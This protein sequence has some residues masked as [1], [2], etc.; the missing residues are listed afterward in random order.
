MP[1]ES[2]LRTG[3]R[4]HPCSSVVALRNDTVNPMIPAIALFLALGFLSLIF[5]ILAWV[6]VWRITRLT[7]RRSQLRWLAAWSLQGLLLPFVLWTLLNV[8]LSFDLQ[9]LMPQV[10]AAKN[11]GNEWFPEFL[12]VVASGLF[13][14]CS[15]WAALTLGWRL[16]VAGAGLEKEAL[17]NF[18]G[19]CLTSL[20]AM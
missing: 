3:I 5:V 2:R 9:P 15:Y 18:K 13:I 19:L 20:F 1:G 11:S 14:I 16:A 12:A 6:S 10:Q 7:K 8:G 4:V 17:S